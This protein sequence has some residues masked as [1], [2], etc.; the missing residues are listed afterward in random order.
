MPA[1]QSPAPLNLEMVFKILVVF[2][3]SFRYIY[4]AIRG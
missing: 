4:A 1:R 2:G 3:G